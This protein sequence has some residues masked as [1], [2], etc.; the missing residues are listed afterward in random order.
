[1]T[2]TDNYGATGIETIIITVNQIGDNEDP[3]IDDEDR[4]RIEL[5]EILLISILLIISIILIIFFIWIGK[6]RMNKKSK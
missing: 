5:S 4:N 2:V 1:L 3:N 6:K